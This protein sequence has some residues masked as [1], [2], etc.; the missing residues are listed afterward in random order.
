MVWRHPVYLWA[1]CI[2]ALVFVGW[3]LAAWLQNRRL[4]RLGDPMVLGV[5]AA[6][7][8]RLVA[9]VLLTVGLMFAAALLPVPAKQGAD[10]GS[11]DPKVMIVIDVSSFD[12]AQD[13]LWSTLEDTIQTIV[14][15][16]PGAHF[17]VITPGL[18]PEVL[19][20]PTL[21]NLGLLIIVSRLPFYPQQQS[22]SDIVE[23]LARLA[24]G[25]A[26]EIANA[27]LLVLTAAPAEEIP[28]LET[29]S[30]GGSPDTTWVNISRGAGSTLYGREGASGKWT[31]SPDPGVLDAALSRS[32]PTMGGSGAINVVQYCALAAFLFLS[33]ESILGLTLKSR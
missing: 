11:P 20:P 17:G 4:K 25:R 22:R 13:R 32:L 9:L 33:V 30:R 19:V 16:A 21:D 15:R 5:S 10:G 29:L 28:R 2:P 27:R 18:P 23:T 24:E 7:F 6:W 14:D 26:A 1:E 12:T 31:W 3:A 8:R